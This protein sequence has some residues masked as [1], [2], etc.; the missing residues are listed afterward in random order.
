MPVEDRQQASKRKWQVVD[1][2]LILSSQRFAV[3]FV[4][5][6]AHVSRILGENS[7]LIDGDQILD[8]DKCIII[9]SSISFISGV[10][11]L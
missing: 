7:T 4:Y 1:A 2:L 3:L 11:F 9:P 10:I 6:T 5:P 8:V